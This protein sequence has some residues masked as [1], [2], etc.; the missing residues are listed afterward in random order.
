MSFDTTARQR[1]APG[2]EEQD[3]PACLPMVSSMGEERATMH[4]ETSA[5]VT[6]QFRHEERDAEPYLMVRDVPGIPGIHTYKAASF[7]DAAAVNS[8]FTIGPDWNDQEPFVISL[9]D[10]Q[11]IAAM[12]RAASER[13]RGYFEMKWVALDPSLPF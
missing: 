7:L 9:D 6:V 1:V 2:A 8:T 13:K 12:V 3:M 4:Y 10:V 5:G 11:S